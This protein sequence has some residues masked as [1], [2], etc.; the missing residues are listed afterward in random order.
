MTSTSGGF[1]R[2]YDAMRRALALAGSPGVPLHPNP[3]VGCVLL[4]DDGR[5]V[6]EGFH[7]GAG[8]PHAEVEALRVAGDEARGATAIVTLE[9]C[10]HTGRTG[11]C[12][13]ALIAA[14][15]RTGGRSPSRDPNPLA[16]GG[17]ETLA[18]AG[19]HRGRGR[20]CSPTEAE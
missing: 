10:N 3:R 20:A 14:G 19:G 15:V 18:A 13:Q 6:G 9:P 12:A 8:T 7:H 11:P 16:S 5:V 4:A 2:E 1:A 17:M